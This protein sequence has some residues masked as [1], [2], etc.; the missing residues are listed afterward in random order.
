MENKSLY[1]I[2]MFR[3]TDAPADFK[4]KELFSTPDTAWALFTTPVLRP[5]IESSPEGPKPDWFSVIPPSQTCRSHFS[6]S[7]L[8]EQ[9]A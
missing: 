5:A 1:A 9:L 7:D 4:E 6:Q 2:V 3:C 8:A